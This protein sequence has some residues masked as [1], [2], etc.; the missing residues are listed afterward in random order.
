M[1]RSATR[2]EAVIKKLKKSYEGTPYA[3]QMKDYQEAST[4]DDILLSVIIPARNEFPNVCHTMYSIFHC[5]EADGFNPKDIEIII[6]NNASD[7]YNDSKFEPNK[8]GIRGTT[9]HLLPRGAFWSRALRVHYAPIAG[10]HAARNK[11]AEIARGKYLFFSD[12]HMAYKPGFFKYGLKAVEESGGIV[13]GAIEW[14]GAYPSH[15]PGMQY[16][17]KL[18]EEW[19]G[20]WNNYS[21]WRDKWF[22][23]PS[24]GHCS[25]LVNRKQFL[26]FGG[27]PSVHR[28]YGGG[29]F[30]TNMKWWMFG[31]TVATEPRS[32]GY[33]LSSGRGYEWTTDD[34]IHNVFNCAYALGCD[35]WLERAYIN[36]IRKGGRK[37]LLD[38]FMREAKVEM[39]EDRK[40]IENRRVRTF[41]ETIVEL[42]WDK[43]NIKRGGVARSS[44][45]IFQDT[46][47]DLLYENDGASKEAIKVYENSQIQKDLEKFINEKLDKYVYKRKR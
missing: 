4:K 7:D 20:T 38:K 2:V 28:T 12:A 3:L 33:H 24:Q 25:V 47:L 35:D 37:P 5:W 26:D 9:E 30:Y 44:L 29:E 18:G 22:Y 36:W 13:H 19:K 41:N 39:A 42:P 10:N 45:S 15:N 1:S 8:P 23:I 14:M 43:L 16:T 34:Y 21:P 27:Y 6:V 31:S 11:G 46:W 17:I 40:F 32:I